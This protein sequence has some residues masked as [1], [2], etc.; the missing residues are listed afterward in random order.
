MTDPQTA[1][2]EALA[3]VAPE[4]DLSAL[5]PDDDLQ[6]AL[7]LDS[8][9]FLNFLIGLAQRTGIEIPESDSPRV[10]TYNA[11]VQYLEDRLS[12]A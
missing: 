1:I 4:A 12:A 10:R 7:D 5:A 3:A 2:R 11:C 9:D 6:D 8:M